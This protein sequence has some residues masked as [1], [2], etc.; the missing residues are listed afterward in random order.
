ME[1]NKT[2]QDMNVKVP[3]IS[4]IA[5]GFGD[6]GCNFSWMFVGNFLMIF[7]TDVCAIPMTAVSLLMLISRFWDAIND[8]II[9]SLSDRTNTRWGRYRPWL[10]IGAPLTAIILVLTFW[11][12]TGPTGPRRS[13]CMSPTAFWYAG[14]PASISPMGPSAAR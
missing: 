7:Y 6:V 8:P 11:A 4:K 10:L 9:G 2:A 5:Y 13:I 1:A 3:L 12:P 14:T